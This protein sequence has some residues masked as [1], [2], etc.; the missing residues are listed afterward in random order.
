MK[1]ALTPQETLQGMEK[2]KNKLIKI[3]KNRLLSARNATSFSRQ[4]AEQVPLYMRQNKLLSTRVE[5]SCPLQKNYK[6]LSKRDK[7]SCTARDHRKRSI[8]YLRDVI[9]CSSRDETSAHYCCM[10]HSTEDNASISLQEKKKAFLY[11]R[12]SS[13]N[14]VY[15]RT[16][17]AAH[18][19]Y[20]CD[21][22][23][24]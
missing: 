1:Q 9:R 11:T 3:D 4:E 15:K 5:T 7:T 10:V 16:G 13:C 6:V 23:Y 2:S 21:H 22:I 18:H 12:K 20:K 17:S 8:Q 14:A 24:H 19:L